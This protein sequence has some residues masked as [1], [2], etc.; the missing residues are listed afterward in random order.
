MLIA[1]VFLLTYLGM[2]AGRLPGLRADRSWIAASAAL[3]LLVSG[4]VSPGD[5]VR[6]LDGETL[7]LLFALMIVSA[8]FRFSGI[9]DRL[10]SYLA[11]HTDRPQ[12]LLFGVVLAAGG[13]SAVLVNDIVAFALTPV[14]LAGLQRTGLD[15]VPYLLA[16]ACACNAGSAMSLIGNPQNILIGQRGG[17]DFWAYAA[18]AVIPS[19]LAMLSVFGVIALLWR[20]RWWLDGAAER[21]RA[22]PEIPAGQRSSLWKPWLALAGLLLLFT[23]PMAREYAALAVAAAVMLSRYRDSRDYVAAVDGN[24]LLLFAGLFVVT[25]SAAELP[26]VQQAAGALAASGLLPDSASGLAA[27]S[28]AGSNLI[29]NV[30]FVMLLLGV[31]PELSP[32]QLQALALLATLAGNFLLVGSVVNLIVAESARHHGIRLGFFR[33]ARVGIPVTLLSM[34][35]A[36]AWLA[37]GAGLPLF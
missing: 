11:A 5:A 4:A 13:L 7:L 34:G 19:L 1:T 3:L 14:L 15:P 36:V 32:A 6:W 37:L 31:G 21:C 9:Y 20:G 24:L 18:F 28:L 12:R 25:G 35:L 27:L 30:P 10:G 23:T 26:Q 8:Q 33:F 2:A 16:L 17:L 29:G 22:L